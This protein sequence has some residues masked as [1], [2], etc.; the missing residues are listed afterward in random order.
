MS[1]LDISVEEKPSGKCLLH[2]WV[3]ERATAALDTEDSRP[4][5]HKRGHRGILSVDLSSRVE[6]DTTVKTDFTPPKGT[7]VRQRGIRGELLEKQLY[8]EISKQTLTEFN[9]QPPK[10][11]FC[12]TTQKDFHMKGFL[13]RLPQ[14][15]GEHDYKRDQ[16]I[17]F[18]NEN[19]SQVQGVTPVRTRDSPFKKNSSFSTPIIHQLHPPGMDASD[20]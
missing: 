17:S 9:P 20:Y 11:E 13:P 2:N 19:H 16:A 10:T 12:S 1:T 15:T 4:Q 14:L 18:W 5:I 8:K 3:E 6:G 7:G